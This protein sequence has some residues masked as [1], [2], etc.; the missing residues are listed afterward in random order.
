MASSTS[1]ASSAPS[2]RSHATP[3]ETFFVRARRHE[4]SL[5]P[6]LRG[7]IALSDSTD[8]AGGTA[9]RLEHAEDFVDLLA[10]MLCAQRTPQQ[11]HVGRR[12][13]RTREVHV[14]ALVQKGLPH[15]R[16]LLEVGHDD[17]DDRRLRLFGAKREAELLSPACSFLRFP[18]GAP[19]CW[20]RAST[21]GS[22]SRRW[23]RRSAAGRR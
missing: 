5:N 14:K 17:R 22:R 10:G 16:A 19:A 18:R 9:C 15:R 13:G 3:V 2:R 23:P 12:R 8:A 6:H 1:A 11:G 7:A 4:V 21:C 20:I